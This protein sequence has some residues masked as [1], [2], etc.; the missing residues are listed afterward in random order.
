MLT[1]VQRGGATHEKPPEVV[2]GTASRLPWAWDGL[3]FGVPFNDS[4]RDA[5]RDLV[6]NAPPST[7]SNYSFVKDD[8]GNVACHLTSTTSGTAGYFEYP[9]N[10]T[11]RRP[12]T[13]ITAYARLRKL[14]TPDTGGAAFGKFFPPGQAPYV[15]WT[16][17]DDDVFSS[18]GYAAELSLATN[19][20]FQLGLNFSVPTTAYYSIFLRWRSGQA[21]TLDLLDERGRLIA[22]ATNGSTLTDT[23]DYD[24]STATP[25]R[26]NCGDVLP[27]GH[28]FWANYS[29]CMLWARRL[30]DTE[31]QALV[32]DP[33]GWYSPRRET[34]GV[35]SPYP[36]FGRESFMREVPSG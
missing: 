21:I 26:V 25:I 16:I 15:S 32:A 33:F 28:S 12:T 13:A 23:V 34:L 1:I 22:S 18:G 24:P 14:G 5:A 7:A 9:S 35:S 36:L 30:T 29:Q 6:Y 8:R 27:P 2:R 4:T 17:H 3:C 10:P 20:N 11:Q 19:G 31:L